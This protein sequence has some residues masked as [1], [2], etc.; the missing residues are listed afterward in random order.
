MGIRGLTP[1]L[2][3]FAPGALSR[4]P[5]SELAGQHVAVDGDQTMWRLFHGFSFRGQRSPHGY[6]RGVVRLVAA[7]RAAGAEPVVAFDAGGGRG[8]R[9]KAR[10]HKLRSAKRD[11]QHIRGEALKR[12]AT[13][14]A[15][16]A[17]G[18]ERGD[19]GPGAPAVE[20]LRESFA[21]PVALSKTAQAALAERERDISD[22][23]PLVNPTLIPPVLPENPR[24]GPE[25]RRA[26]ADTGNYLAGA[27]GNFQALYTHASDGSVSKSLKEATAN[28]VGELALLADRVAPAGGPETPRELPERHRRAVADE[29]R[30]ISDEQFERFQVLNTRVDLPSRRVLVEPLQELLRIMGVQVHTAPPGYEGECLAASLCAAGIAAGGVMTTDTD[31]VLYGLTQSSGIRLIAPPQAKRGRERDLDIGELDTVDV[32]RA[33]ELLDLGPAEFLDL[34][35]LLGTDFAPNLPGIGPVNALRLIRKHGT[36]D[37]VL[38]DP[39]TARKLPPAALEE[40]SAAFSEAR[41]IF[42]SLV[43]VSGPEY[44]PQPVQD[45]QRGMAHARMF[46]LELNGRAMAPEAADTLGGDP[47]AGELGGIDLDGAYQL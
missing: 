25:V 12:A 4:I 47:Y 17:D 46:L 40:A 16:V 15:V 20:R 2:R 18:I 33:L 21:E 45:P 41:T 27:M 1:F 9:Q 19:L 6:L 42:S 36:L 26:L 11:G 31:A 34:C 5:A 14:L 35:L 22:V 23:A 37:A 28:I 44:A 24:T 30:R 10:E 32:R 38:A 39:E 29:I 7:L 3:R 43:D 8:P 13:L